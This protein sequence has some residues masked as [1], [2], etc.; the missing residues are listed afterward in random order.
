MN[1]RL[2]EVAYKLAVAPEEF[3]KPY[4]EPLKEEILKTSVQSSQ[5]TIAQQRAMAEMEAITKEHADALYVGGDRTKLTPFAR[6]VEQHWQRLTGALKA[7]ASPETY[8]EAIARA[9]M[10]VAT[11]QPTA[12]P[13]GDEVTGRCAPTRDAGDELRRNSDWPTRTSSVDLP[14]LRL[15]ERCEPKRNRHCCLLEG[16]GRRTPAKADPALPLNKTNP[17]HPPHPP[18]N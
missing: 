5:Q 8:R 12:S 10:E 3:L 14:W 7:E 9:Q 4:I 18:L 17:P 6:K 2:Q 16:G 1:R 13:A 15:S 11:P